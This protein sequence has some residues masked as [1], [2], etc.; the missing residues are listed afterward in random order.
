[1]SVLDEDAEA[2][3]VNPVVSRVPATANATADAE[4][5][6][7]AKPPQ[8]VNGQSASAGQSIGAQAGHV[9]NGEA[10]VNRDHEYGRHAYPPP[11]VPTRDRG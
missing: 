7:L 4:P 5:E 6:L 3:E 9:I 1:M 11:S 10:R 8:V 2:F